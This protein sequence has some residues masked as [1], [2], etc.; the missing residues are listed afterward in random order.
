MRSQKN[1][2]FKAPCYNPC[3]ISGQIFY[4]SSHE[5]KSKTKLKLIKKTWQTSKD[6]IILH[7]PLLRDFIYLNIN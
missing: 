1:K 6:P 3:F 4:V 2:N 5:R 7:R